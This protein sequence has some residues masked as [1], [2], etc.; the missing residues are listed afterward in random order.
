MHSLMVEAKVFTGFL[1]SVCAGEG[2]RVSP[3]LH[4]KHI[5]SHPSATAICHISH[6]WQAT[7]FSIETPLLISNM[8]ISR[9]WWWLRG[10]WLRHQFEWRPSESDA[11][12]RWCSLT[13]QGTHPRLGQ[14]LAPSLTLELTHTLARYLCWGLWKEV[15]VVITKVHVYPL[16]MIEQIGDHVNFNN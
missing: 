8:L 3:T 7:V 1:Q 9:A 15:T 6:K 14:L 4:L 16:P 12:Q 13:S 5:W 11:S 10:G 2:R